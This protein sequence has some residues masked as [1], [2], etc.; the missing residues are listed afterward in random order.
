MTDAKRFQTPGGGVARSAPLLGDATEPTIFELSTKGRRAS[1][2]RGG[3]VDPETVA[4]FLPPSQRRESALELPEVSERDL[5]G[6]YTRLSSRQYSVDLG[7]YP[8]GSCTMKYNPKL[9]DQVAQIPGLSQIHPQSPD[10]AIQG[11][12]E[13]LCQLEEV[14]CEI[15][16]M[17][18][19]TT[20]PSA[21]AAG[22][23]TG[24]LMMRAYHEA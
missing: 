22:E 13:L 20:Q 3:A 5:V 1:A 8:L 18:A 23:L 15:T 14:I 19:A 6:H 21:G 24:L 12:L 17:A 9:A 10:S 11:W 4:G 2:I 16:G 7:A